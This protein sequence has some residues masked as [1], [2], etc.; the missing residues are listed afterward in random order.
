MYKAI[1]VYLERRKSRQYVGQLYKEKR[2]FVFQYDDS[3][4]YAD[5]PIP[6]G[7]DLSL[8]Q[9]KHISLKLFPSFEDRI[10]SKKNPAYEKYC[11]DVGINSSE[12]NPLTLL[13]KLGQKGPSSFVCVPIIEDQEFSRGDLK[14]FRKELKL[15]IRE[16]SDLFDISSSTIYRIENNKT[17]GKDTLKKIAVYFKSPKTAL[18]Q[19]KITGVKINEHKRHVVESFFISQIKRPVPIGPFTVT[20]DDIKRCT[21]QQLIELLKRLALLECDRYNISQ[22]SVDF[23]GNILAK[24]GGQDGLVTWSQGPPYTNYFPNRYNCFQVKTD[25]LSPQKCKKE[26]YDKKGQLKMA[27]QNVIK[28]QGAY[29]LCSTQPVSG[30]YVRAREE[31]LEEE[32]EKAGYDS[33]QID[34]KFYDADK[35]AN[36]L[37]QYPSLVVWFFKEVLNKSKTPWISWQEWNREEQ[38]YSLEFMCNAELRSKKDNIYSILSEPRKTVHL[39]GA[40]GTGKTRLALETFRPIEKFNSSN[41]YPDL[42]HLILYSSAGNLKSSHL[43]ELKTS[44][45]ILVIDDC[46]LAEAEAFHKIAIQEDSRLSLLTIGNEETEKGLQYIIRKT[47]RDIKKHI[48]KLEPSEEIVKKILSETQNITNKYIAPKYLELTSGLPLMA[49]LLKEVGHLDLLKDDIPTIKNKMLWGKQKPDRN[50]EKVIKAC[51]LFDT[52]GMSNKRPDTIFSPRHKSRG[53]EEAEYIAKEICE[54]DYDTFYKYVEVFKKKNIIQQHGRFIQ[55]RPK[56]LAAW[57]ASELIEH[58]PPESIV[59]WLVNMKVSQ[60]N[61]S[62]KIPYPDEKKNNFILWGIDGGLRESFCKQLSYLATFKSAQG[63]VEKLCDEKGFFG[64]EET[65][66]TEWGFHCLYHLAELNSK[67]TLKSIENIFDDK[68]IEEIEDIPIGGFLWALGKKTISSELIWALEKIAR[69]KELYLRSS[70]LL[71]RFAEIEVNNLWATHAKDVFVSHFQLYLSGTEAGPDIKFKIIREIKESGT[72]K[73]KE[74]AIEALGQALKTKEF[75]RS[76]EA[77]QTKSGRLFEDWQPKTY[78]EQWNYFR[79]ALKYLTHFATKDENQ[80][81]NK[82]ACN[83]IAINLI[84]LLHQGLYNE[85]ET[86][87]KAVTSIHGFY[88]PSVVTSLMN[89]LKY[90]SKKIKKE[91]IKKIQDIIELLQPKENINERLK[92][93]IIECPWHYIYND[94]QGEKTSEYDKQFEQ[95]L[96]D[97]KNLLKTGD[98]KQKKSTLNILFHGEQRNTSV[99]SYKLVNYLKNPDQFVIQLL[100]IIETWK[101]DKDFNPSFLCGLIKGLNEWNPNKTKQILDKIATDVN[102]LDFLIPAYFQLKL[103]NQ[104]ITRLIK[105]IG[106]TNINLSELKILSA[107]KRCNTVDL[108]IMEQLISTLTEKNIDAGW[109][110]LNIYQDY[111]YDSEPEKK[112]KLANALYNLLTQ[113][114]FLSY[115]KGYDNDDCYEDAVDDVLASEYGE[116]FAQQFAFQIFNSKNSLFDFAVRDSTIKECF[117]KIFKKYPDI[118]FSEITN[119]IN[120]HKMRF[121][122]QDK[123]SFQQKPFNHYKT[124][125]LS[126]LTD[127]QLKDW[128]KKAPDKIPVFLAKN[129]NL[130]NNNDELSSLFKFLLDEYGEQKRFTGAIS[131][132]LGTFTWSGDLSIYFEKIKKALESLRDHKHK[133]VREFVMR[134]ISYLDKEIDGQKQRQKEINEFSIW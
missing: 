83:L 121:I 124:S 99:F 101:R 131:T 100:E 94:L 74:I 51:A 12:K 111:V 27:L 52:I 133:N 42:S 122:F 90:Q 127:E 10:P 41:K 14:Q 81:I 119:N 15:S 85:V 36:W 129:M 40:S 134:E 115:K 87:I 59:N 5:N 47:T 112:K 92:F 66:C 63:L 34:I 76:S 65:L 62:K 32:I 17:S 37:N 103:Q 79:T 26:I 16:F 43:R 128:C 80:K 24:D 130:F 120:D 104:D 33:K 22:N 98:R 30:V 35:I 123:N 64:K 117:R 23:S 8:N 44:R 114:D 82:T 38:D 39:A 45:V 68:S 118:L 58:T 86:A 70:R 78:D 1:D 60:P 73:Q 61:T 113:K 49:K 67:A 25:S 125:P 75:S 88:W 72:I 6:L 9:Q 18:E 91:N 71:L 28:K 102:F 2:K 21:P 89:F 107:G 132:N 4:L 50:G 3:Y 77:M 54:M 116:R 11:R 20:F 93:Y 57:L 106:E 84:P 29:I 69:E 7:P 96:V 95:L 105:S 108:H 109:V 126:S 55:V 110:A 46:S 31:A 19:I 53:K 97:F 56:P 13:A 48:I